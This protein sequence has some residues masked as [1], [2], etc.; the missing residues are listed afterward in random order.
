M[1]PSEKERRYARA[2]ENIHQLLV[3][4]GTSCGDERT[5]LQ[6][7]KATVKTELYKWFNGERTN[8]W[9]WAGYY[10]VASNGSP[11]L[12]VSHYQ[13]EEKG[14]PHIPFERGV[15]GGSARTRRT[16]IVPNVH[17]EAWFKANGLDYIPCDKKTNSE[18]VVPVLDTRRKL[19]CVFDVDSTK[20][21]AFDEVDQHW[22]QHIQRRF[23]TLW[24]QYA[25]P[26]RHSA[27]VPCE[28]H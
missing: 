25:H 19:T 2:E 1:K 8:G 23:I 27:C 7:A 3:T 17:D 10:D 12:W 6:I 9:N 5:C 18:I 24:R 11:E 21:R 22:L 4:E 13:G 26:P 20:L 16:I 14:C 15:C 28:A